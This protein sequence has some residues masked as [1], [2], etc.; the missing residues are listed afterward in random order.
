MTDLS[1]SG[2][3][4]L[5]AASLREDLGSGDVTSGALVPEDAVA[6]A[7]FVSKESLV[8]AGIPV[9]RELVRMYDPAL[10]FRAAVSDGARVSAGT[11]LIEVEGRARAIFAVERTSLNFLQRLSGIASLT[12]R[13]VA[14]VEGTKAVIVDT[15][16]TIPGHRLLD[17]YGVRCGGGA[18]HRTGLFDA[19]LIKNNHLEFHPDAGTAVALA[20]EKA[21]PMTLE[22]EVRDMNELESALG[23]GPDVI[24]LDN[25]TLELT[26][27][28]VEFVRGRVVLESSGGIN[29]LN[30]RAYAEAGVDR[31]SVGALTHSAPASDIH[32]RVSPL[33]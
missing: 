32:L 19:I 16:K 11:V 12:R 23:A 8:A 22:V 4:D 24:M 17:K 3:G 6:R 5:L 33:P 28:A 15:R 7:E 26:S 10:E 13:Y 30:V 14:A 25:F 1:F 27:K 9:V 29:L 18:N 31:I 21:G 20:R 2:I